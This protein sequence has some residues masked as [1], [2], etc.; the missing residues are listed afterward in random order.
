M[1]KVAEK[2]GRSAAQILLRFQVQRGVVI[3]PKSANEKR[4]I[5]NFDMF[6]FKLDDADMTLLDKGNSVRMWSEERVKHSK[7]FPKW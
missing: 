6:S 3:I 1:L 7:Y 4:Q 5:D 2:H